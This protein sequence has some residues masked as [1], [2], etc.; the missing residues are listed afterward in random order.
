M[1]GFLAFEF[2]YGYAL[3]FDLRMNTTSKDPETYILSHLR[4]DKEEDQRLNYQH[5]LIKH[6]ILDGRL[7]HPVIAD[8]EFKNGIADIGCG[9]G[10]WLDNMARMISAQGR[11]TESNGR[12]LVGFDVNVHAFN[13]KPGCRRSI[14]RA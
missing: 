8:R 10:I 6:A 7:L 9:T 2:I 11:G 1:L 13:P 5:E 14:N 3:C 4:E 12:M